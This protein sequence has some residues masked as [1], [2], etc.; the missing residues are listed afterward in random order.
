MTVEDRVSECLAPLE[1]YF[2]SKP[3]LG[4]LY[5]QIAERMTNDLLEVQKEMR[6]QCAQEADRWVL[7]STDGYDLPGDWIRDLEIT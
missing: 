5:G 2:S 7:E 4:H 1:V 6:E 3:G